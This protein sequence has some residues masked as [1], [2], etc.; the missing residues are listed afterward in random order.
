MGRP[1][2]GV[3]SARRCKGPV[4]VV[5]C[6]GAAVD[7][8]PACH[9]GGVAVRR[10]GSPEALAWLS[11]QGAHAGSVELKT[12]LLPPAGPAA[13]AL[14][15]RCAPTWSVR[16]MYLL[17]TPSL[18]LVR[19]G[20]EIRLRRRARGRYD[21]SVC[22]RR[23]GTARERVIPPGVRVEFD[24]V[25]G[26]L[27]QDIEVRREVDAVA[28]RAVIA[29]EATSRELL[30]ASQRAWARNGGHEVVG[31]AQLRGLRVHGPLV[32]HRVKVAA[33]RLG[34]R[35]ADLEHFRYPSGRELMELSTR[36][37]PR[38]VSTTASA[39]EQLLDERD[40]LVAQAHRTKASVWQDEIETGQIT[41]T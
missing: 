9:L 34:L 37:S 27:W 30:S 22:A 2:D 35:R 32:V 40:V 3:I 39:F 41:R 29:G 28:A 21:L 38:E 5:Q 33:E 10:F 36:C 12:L 20:V 15:G 7:V 4:A 17:D 11:T 24:V 8:D 25:P 31:D 23:S 1:V 18:D 13:E 19:A 14:T 26:A 16:Q 6:W